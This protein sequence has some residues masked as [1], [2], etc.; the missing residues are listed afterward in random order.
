MMKILYQ[1]YSILIDQTRPAPIQKKEYI[2]KHD[3]IVY[4]L[5]NYAKLVY[6]GK[7]DTVLMNLK[8]L[9]NVVKLDTMIF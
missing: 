1:I 2:F 8:Y 7:G 9:C 4:Y 6:D 3:V 5:L